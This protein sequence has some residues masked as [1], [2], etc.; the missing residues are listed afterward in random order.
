M[1]L[2][3]AIYVVPIYVYMQDLQYMHLRTYLFGKTIWMALC[4]SL[5]HSGPF[6]L[7][8]FRRSSTSFSSF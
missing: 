8:S 5:P 2:Y 4:S 6:K 3:K 7:V 1:V